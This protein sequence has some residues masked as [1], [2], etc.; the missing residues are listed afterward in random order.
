MGRIVE[1]NEAFTG[2]PTSYDPNNS[3]MSISELF[4]TIV[5]KITV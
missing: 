5:Y 1:H 2:S 4:I 3:Q